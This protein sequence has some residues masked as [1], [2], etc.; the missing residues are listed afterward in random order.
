MTLAAVVI[1]AGVGSR[2]RPLTETWAKPLLPVDGT[3]VLA[4]LLREL[5]AAGCPRA[6]IVTGH[7]AEQ[8]ERLVGDGSSFG[9]EVAYARQASP[10]GSA[11]AVAVA[12]AVPPYLVVGADTVFTPGDVSRV[13]AALDGAAGVLA[14][15]RRRDGEPVRN[16]VGV[17]DGWIERLHV[18]E[19]EHAGAPLWAVGPA[20]AARIDERPG[21]PP[22]ELATAF[23][24]AIDAGERIRAV[25]IGPTRDLTAPADLLRENFPYL[26][27]L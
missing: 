9:L 10:D 18:E 22:F 20:V 24:G 16:G 4:H 21:D 14:V 15:R 11:D 19:G 26:S 27:T 13:A 23:Q 1:A 7:L 25:E 6:T 5:A 8:V 2:M 3:P 12:G 17:R